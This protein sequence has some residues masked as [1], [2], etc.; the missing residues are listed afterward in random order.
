MSGVPSQH[1]AYTYEWQWRVQTTLP[2]PAKSIGSNNGAWSSGARSLYLS[3][4]NNAGQDVSSTFRQMKIG[5]TIRIEHKT[6][7]TIWSLWKLD[8]APIEYSTCFTFPSTS[9]EYHGAPVDNTVYRVVITFVEP[10]TERLAIGEHLLN[11][12]VIANGMLG[13]ESINLAT[14]GDDAIKVYTQLVTAY[15][16][17][18]ELP[19]PVPPPAVP[20]AKAL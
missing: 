16:A 7:S 20:V 17:T 19:Q 6:D 9:V 11:L 13:K 12:S 3:N 5:D 1:P 2:P 8:V 14:I 18:P 10:K 15:L 4:T